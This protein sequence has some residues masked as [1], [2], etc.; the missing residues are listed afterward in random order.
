MTEP[1]PL[2]LIPVTHAEL[3]QR[4][5]RWISKS[6]GCG[7]YFAELSTYASSIPDVIAWKWGGGICHLVECKTSRSDF[8]RDEKKGH[9]RR[10]KT[11]GSR[12]W[13]FTPPG[14]LRPEEVEA[15]GWG[16]VEVHA[17]SCRVVVDAPH[18]VEGR[19]RKEE[20]ALLFSACRRHHLGVP[21]YRPTGRFDPGDGGTP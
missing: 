3:V 13:Y 7:V 4:A 12:R 8:L 19:D 18:V 2:Q 17:K 1:V 9:R 16:L 10:G 11:P 6:Q 20:I 21:F 15:I 14:L 5:V